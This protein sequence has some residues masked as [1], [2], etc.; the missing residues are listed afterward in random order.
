MLNHLHLPL[1]VSDDLILIQLGSIR[2][3]SVNSDST[4]YPDGY[5]SKILY[6]SSNKPYQKEW[7]TNKITYQDG[8]PKFTVLDSLSNAYVGD[9]PSYPWGQIVSKIKELN[10]NIKNVYNFGHKLFGFENKSIICYLEELKERFISNSDEVKY[11]QTYETTPKFQ[12]SAEAFTEMV[13]MII[14]EKYLQTDLS[15]IKI[16]IHRLGEQYILKFLEAFIIARPKFYAQVIGFLQNFSFDQ[17]LYSKAGISKPLIQ[18]IINGDKRYSNIFAFSGKSCD[19]TIEDFINVLISDQTNQNGEEYYQI[20]IRSILDNSKYS[21]YELA[22]KFESINI[23]NSC[24]IDNVTP[25]MKALIMSSPNETIFKMNDKFN[26]QTYQFTNQIKYVLSFAYNISELFSTFRNPLL[27]SIVSTNNIISVM[28]LNESKVIRLKIHLIFHEALIQNNDFM[29]KNFNVLNQIKNN[30]LLEI[31]AKA[32]LK[33]DKKIQADFEQIMGIKFTA[34]K[35]FHES[36]EKIPVDRSPITIDGCHI[37]FECSKNTDIEKLKSMQL[38]LI[39]PGIHINV[40][41]YE[42]TLKFLEQMPAFIHLGLSNISSDRSVNLNYF[43]LQN[44]D[45]SPLKISHCMT[46]SYPLNIQKYQIRCG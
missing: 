44:E 40:L 11:L 31:L 32:C 22:V 45:Y 18:A 19:L 6:Y 46:K 4:I 17:E 34:I 24:N 15:Q 10:R 26:L 21:F 42:Q 20:R 43:L 7:Y 13:N 29:Y 14:S 30:D 35:Q 3:N 8:K 23:L 27:S 36:I 37:C 41:T 1:N 2:C 33:A 5:I 16:K 9:S 12:K 39:S 38:I 28:N 25:I